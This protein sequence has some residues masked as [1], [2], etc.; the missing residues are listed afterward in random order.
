MS[1]MLPSDPSPQP[2]PEI[3]FLKL[4]V[5]VLTGTMIAGL[6]TIIALLVIRLP[7]GD[8]VIPQLPAHIVLPEGETVSA[9]TFAKGYSVVVTASGKILIYGADGALRQSVL[10]E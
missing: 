2:L 10:A 3:R 9:L 1:D 4:L 6:L 5:T 8:A 7:S